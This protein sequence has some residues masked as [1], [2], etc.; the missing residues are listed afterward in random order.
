MN[1]DLGKY[2]KIGGQQVVK[3]MKIKFHPQDIVDEHRS[4]GDIIPW[5]TFSSLTAHNT[6]FT[7][8]RLDLDL[9]EVVIP[10]ASLGVDSPPIEGTYRLRV[11]PSPIGNLLV[12]FRIKP[13]RS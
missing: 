2:C 3:E 7:A 11:P 5:D 8:A 10:L 4:K 1:M 9:R 13:T 12:T 6:M